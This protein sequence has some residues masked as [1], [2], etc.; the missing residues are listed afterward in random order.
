M[1]CYCRHLRSP[2]QSWETPEQH[3]TAQSVSLTK[4]EEQ[5][6]QGL[7]PQIDELPANGA[8]KTAGFSFK[9][10]SA[11]SLSKARVRYQLKKI[12]IIIESASYLTYL[13]SGGFRLC[14]VDI[15]EEMYLSLLLSIRRTFTKSLSKERATTALK[16][17]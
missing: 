11:L 17:A 13:E 7:V 4:E 16:R 1:G 10:L 9:W 14:V 5:G 3:S 8:R 6:K 12:I 2:E 15:P